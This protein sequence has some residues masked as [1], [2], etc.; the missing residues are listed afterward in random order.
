MLVITGKLN[1]FT[2]KVL[3]VVAALYTLNCVDRL[4]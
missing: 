3:R 1:V 2:A 4:I